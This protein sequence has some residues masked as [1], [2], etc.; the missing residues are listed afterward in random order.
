MPTRGSAAPWRSVFVSSLLSPTKAGARLAM[1]V[2]VVT[3]S[4]AFCL[5]TGGADLAMATNA[6]LSAGLTA[7]VG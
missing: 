7:L 1:L 3:A 2:S 5:L 6:I 4:A